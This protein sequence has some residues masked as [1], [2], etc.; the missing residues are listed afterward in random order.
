MET[1]ARTWGEVIPDGKWRTMTVYGRRPLLPASRM[2]VE[3]Y[4]RSCPEG[5]I[6]FDD[7]EVT[8]AAPPVTY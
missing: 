5:Y 8:A 3:M 1:H 7:L 2:V 6:C 4:A